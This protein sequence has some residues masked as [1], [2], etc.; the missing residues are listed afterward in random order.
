VAGVPEE[1]SGFLE[2][3]PLPAVMLDAGGVVVGHNSRFLG[4]TGGGTA[5][6]DEPAGFSFMDPSERDMARSL[7]RGMAGEGS[8][9]LRATLLGREGERIRALGFWS[10]A[11]TE[12]DGPGRYIGLFIEAPEAERRDAAAGESRPA[13]A[14][15]G[16]DGSGEALSPGDRD[17]ADQARREQIIHTIIFHDA[18]NRLAALHGYASLL[19]ESLA[20]SGFLSYLDKLDEIAT[21]IERDLGV[22]SMFSHLGL[23]APRWQNLREIVGK[24]ASRETGGRVSLEGVPASIW[25]LADPLFPR[26]FSNLF[27]NARRHGERV[28]GIR[29]RTTEGDAGLVISVEDD[30]I[31]VPADQKERIFELGFGRHTGYGLYLARE[32]L[33]I[34]GFSIRET[35]EPGKGARFDIHVPRGRYMVRPSCPEEADTAKIPAV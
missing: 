24:S 33:S 19:R 30:G 17:A 32:I 27:E 23:I 35:G 15:R 21:E 31:G 20:G 8:V 5:L 16:T 22:A 7:L 6:R 14:A 29:I 1:S 12:G 4:L 10:L 11:G 26:V 34:A 9:T 3:I 25:C 13:A 18:K 2:R 28:T